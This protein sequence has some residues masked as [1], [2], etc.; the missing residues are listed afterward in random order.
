MQS[1]LNSKMKVRNASKIA[2]KTASKNE[3][4]FYRP[5]APL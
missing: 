4:N 3:L 5:K 1:L 2:S